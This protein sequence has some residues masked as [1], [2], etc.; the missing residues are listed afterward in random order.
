MM[1]GARPTCIHDIGEET[2]PGRVRGLT[3]ADPLRARMPRVGS[4]YG[5]FDG[6]D[7]RTRRKSERHAAGSN[8]FG[9]STAAPRRRASYLRAAMKTGISRSVFNWYSA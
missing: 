1:F 3:R 8:R 4:F 5:W 2:R 7:S 9:W 6:A